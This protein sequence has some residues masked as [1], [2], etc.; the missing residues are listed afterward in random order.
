MTQNDLERDGWTE[1]GRSM[2]IGSK[3]W[4]TNCK[5]Q[6][7]LKSVCDCDNGSETARTGIV[8]KEPVLEPEP[9]GY[10]EPEPHQNPC[11]N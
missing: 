3:I 6:R 1:S 5:R 7:R 9:F 4:R 11:L 8:P 2:N 10:R